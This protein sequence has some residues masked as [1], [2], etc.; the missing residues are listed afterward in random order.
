MC[1]LTMSAWSERK[2]AS[3]VHDMQT[4]H[5]FF[6][7]KSWNG[8]ILLIGFFYLKW[9]T[10]N[11]QN[12]LLHC[13]YPCRKFFCILTTHLKLYE[14]IFTCIVIIYLSLNS[15]NI[16]QFIRSWILFIIR[17]DNFHSATFKLISTISHVHVSIFSK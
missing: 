3:Q 4:P 15:K 5:F 9:C 10:V 7:P 17:M 14:Y 2:L 16:I 1:S 13:V 11:I 6:L 8:V 12:K